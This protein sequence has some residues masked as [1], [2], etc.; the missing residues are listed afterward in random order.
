MK[1][2]RLIL[3]MEDR[4]ESIRQLSASA[5][6]FCMLVDQVRLRGVNAMDPRLSEAFE[7]LRNAT[8]HASEALN[9]EMPDD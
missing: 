2:R 7:L 4:I 3:T 8:L 5:R 1:K 9:G 6:S